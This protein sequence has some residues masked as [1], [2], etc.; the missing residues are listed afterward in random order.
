MK[1]KNKFWNN[2]AKKYDL[3][4]SRHAQSTY[5]ILINLI[6]KE[7]QAS[8]EMLEIGTGTGII[9]IA[10]ATNVKNI[11]ATDFA[12]AMIDV[13]LKKPNNPKNIEFQVGSANK[14]QYSNN[15]FDVV[16]ASNVFHL[17][18]NAKETLREISRVLKDEGKAILPTFCHGQDIKSRIISAFMSLIGFKA[19]NKW[20][21]KEFRYF[22]EK[23]DFTIINELIIKDKIPMSFIVATK[24]K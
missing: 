16:L 9:S 4:I 15:T 6:K 24:G 22:I 14:L 7:L 1:T 19:E 2:Y 13:A 3:F 10:V 5:K 17:I 8:D 20:T 12:P 23:E 18:P 11:K 21:T